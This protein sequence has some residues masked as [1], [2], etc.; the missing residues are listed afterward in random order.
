MKQLY[1][2]THYYLLRLIV[3]LLARIIVA[4]AGL[5]VYFLTGIYLARNRTVVIRAR[6]FLSS[7]GFGAA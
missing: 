5:F 1:Q 2:N 6:R 4:N 3:R 7:I